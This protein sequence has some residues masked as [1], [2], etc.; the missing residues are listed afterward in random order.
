MRICYDFTVSAKGE[1]HD[2]PDAKA[3]FDLCDQ[4]RSE[5]RTGFIVRAQNEKEARQR[6]TSLSPTNRNTDTVYIL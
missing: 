1:R 3:L 2:L 5:G 4:R 6:L